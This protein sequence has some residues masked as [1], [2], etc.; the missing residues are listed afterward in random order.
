MQ[1][2]QSNNACGRLS[3]VV[4]A[5]FAV[6]AATLVGIEWLFGQGRVRPYFADMPDRPFLYAVNTTLSS[7]L[8]GVASVLF[9]VAHHVG[10]LRVADPTFLRMAS[11]QALFY[12]WLAADD[13]FLVHERLPQSLE[14]VY[15]VAL[16]SAYGL[17]V[18][19]H[20]RCLRGRRESAAL[21]VLGGALFGAMMVADLMVPQDARLR[22]SLEDLLKA[23]ASLALAG[24]AWSYLRA[25][26]RLLRPT[27]P[28]STA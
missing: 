6:Y 12:A 18:I 5:A 1:H 7:G 28:A 14:A 16:G 22:L 27:S 25:E 21:L 20:R 13:R 2:S 17:F 15:W 9:I 8:Q 11:V 4:V 26:L 23:A 10:R 24:S 19:L 3:I